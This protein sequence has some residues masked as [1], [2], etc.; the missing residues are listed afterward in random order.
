MRDVL[1]NPHNVGKNQVPHN[2]GLYSL[3][4]LHCEE[5]AQDN[6]VVPHNVGKHYVPHN[7]GIKK[8]P[9]NVGKK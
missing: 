9:H 6:L 1:I 5:L 4:I 3:K 8:V 2:V 7:V